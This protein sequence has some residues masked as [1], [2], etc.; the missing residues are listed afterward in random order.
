MKTKAQKN[1]PQKTYGKQTARGN[2]GERRAAD[3]LRKA[4]YTIRK[5]AAHPHGTDDL[6]A[7]RGSEVRRIQVKRI[8]SRVFSTEQAARNR[9][10]GKPFLIKSIAPGHEVWLFDGNHNLF[11]FTK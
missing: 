3:I 8:S 10:A 2:T 4:G 5:P 11:I 1:S 7:T 6:I 9:L